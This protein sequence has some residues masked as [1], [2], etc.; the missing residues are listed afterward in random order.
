MGVFWSALQ[1]E[2]MTQASGA[3]LPT[4]ERSYGSNKADVSSLKLE[5]KIKEEGMDL[6]KTKELVAASVATLV[7]NEPL[8]EDSKPA[9]RRVL[10]SDDRLDDSFNA[11]VFSVPHPVLSKNP[12]P[13]NCMERAAMATQILQDAADREESKK[14]ADWYAWVED[15]LANLYP[16]TCSTLTAKQRVFLSDN[17]DTNSTSDSSN[18]NSM[19]PS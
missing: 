18:A 13:T 5:D 4:F 17:S 19:S 15:F 9:A 1:D 11:L 12:L 8:F 10:F 2:L 6:D 3:L 7:G 14:R 16:S